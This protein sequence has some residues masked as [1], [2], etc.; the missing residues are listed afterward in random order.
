MYVYIILLSRIMNVINIT[1]LLLLLSIRNGVWIEVWKFF[2]HCHVC[3]HQTNLHKILNPHYR[4][5]FSR[6]PFDYYVIWLEA[7]YLVSAPSQ[8]KKK[9]VGSDFNS[10]NRII[11]TEC[12]LFLYTETE[13]NLVTVSHWGLLQSGLQDTVL[14]LIVF[15]GNKIT[16]ISSCN[17]E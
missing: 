9:T 15:Q 12:P 3:W 16:L 5:N 7:A 8:L 17:K 4:G 13:V 1:D 2:F 6:H 11:P 10:P 14:A